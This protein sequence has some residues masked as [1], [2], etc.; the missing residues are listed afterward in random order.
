MIELLRIFS[1]LLR[2]L[3]CLPFLAV[4]RRSSPFQHQKARGLFEFL[5]ILRKSFAGADGE[6]ARGGEGAEE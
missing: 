1:K 2:F 6:G 5:C 3:V 4:S